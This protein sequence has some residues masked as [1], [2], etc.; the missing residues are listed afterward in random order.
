MVAF[1]FKH[2]VLILKSNTSHAVATSRIQNNFNFDKKQ[3]TSFKHVSTEK[4][5]IAIWDI[6]YSESK[7][8]I[9]IYLYIYLSISIVNQFRYKKKNIKGNEI[10]VKVI[11]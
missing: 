4:T 11:S 7:V 10:S 3:H 5:T 6:L 1:F 8:F 9:Y 2:F